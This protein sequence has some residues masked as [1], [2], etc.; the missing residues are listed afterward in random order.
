M[1]RKAKGAALPKNMARVTSALLRL[2]PIDERDT[3][4]IHASRD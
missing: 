3:C 4:V 2:A 1:P